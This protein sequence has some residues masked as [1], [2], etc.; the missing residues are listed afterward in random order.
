MTMR[1]QCE[2]LKFQVCFTVLYPPHPPPRFCLLLNYL[3]VGVGRKK[4]REGVVTSEEFKFRH[5]KGR[6][7]IMIGQDEIWQ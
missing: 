3:G 6:C 2:L 1:V 4:E 5:R 7:K